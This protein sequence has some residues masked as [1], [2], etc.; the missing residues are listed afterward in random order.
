[1]KSGPLLAVAALL[2]A[3]PLSAQSPADSTP[4][5]GDP[6]SR[7]A[8][9]NWLT[10]DVSFQP[11]GLEEWSGATLNYPLT[12]SDHLFTG[13]DSR[14]ELHIGLNAIRLDANSNFGF[15]NLDDTIVQV[16][17]TEGSLEIRLRVLADDDSFEVATPNGAVTLLRA[18]DYRI[19]TNPERD[20]TMLTVRAGQAELFSGANSVIIRAQETAYFQTD[21]NPDVRAANELDDFDSFVAAREDSAPVIADP[22][23]PPVSRNRAMDRFSD[24]VSVADLVAEGMTGAEDLN[25]YGSWQNTMPYGQAWVPPV[26]PGWV[27]YSDGDWAYVEPWGWTWID[28]APWGFAPFH[29]GRWAY[30]NY[31]WVWVP[32]PKRTTQVYASALV[33]FYGGG[34][35]DNVSWLPLGPRDLWTPAWRPQPDNLLPRLSSNRSAPGAVQSM[36]KRD[37]IAGGRVHPMSGMAPE[38]QVLGSSPMVMPVRESVLV[39][40]S[41][42]RPPAFNRPLI[43]RTAPPLAP[44]SFAATIGLLAQNRGRPRAPHQVEALRRQLPAAVMQR[45]AVRYTKPLVNTPRAVKPVTAKP[46]EKPNTKPNAA[47]PPR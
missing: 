16:S 2:A 43:L 8:R 13:K 18:G 24:N 38:G 20:A 44:V 39:G 37:F 7:V 17:L 11:A 32:G 12:T 19:D 30:A 42:V 15:L 23:S 29:Y 35:A 28:A 34:P 14:V 33:T 47:P 5:P 46:G 3:L 36:S 9:L 25:T 1:M 10:G 27:P 26:D 45:P 22:V 41:R 6:P 31:R 40:A 4:E 21:R